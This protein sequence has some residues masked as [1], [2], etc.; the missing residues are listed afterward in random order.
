MQNLTHRSPGI[1]AIFNAVKGAKQNGILDLG[2]ATGTNL[3]FYSRLG[4]RF[5]FESF[6]QTVSGFLADELTETQILDSFLSSLTTDIKFDVV[7]FWDLLNYLPKPLIEPIVEKLQAV[8]KPNALVHMVNFVG[9]SIP[10]SPAVF[11]VADQYQLNVSVSSDR[12]KPANRVTTVALLKMFPRFL[13]VQSYLN[14]EGMASGFSEQILR[15]GAGSQEKGSV[16]SSSETSSSAAKIAYRINSPAVRRFIS[17]S[18]NVSS[19]L[20]L[21]TKRGFNH[22]FWKRDYQTVVASEL[23]PVI[24][25]YRQC[26]DDDKKDYLENGR[27][28]NIDVSR[29]FDVIIAWD[30]LNYC[31]DALLKAIGQRIAKHCNDGTILVLM[32]YSGSEIPASPQAF[33][34]DQKGV[35]L[36]KSP[37]NQKL[38]KK[39]PKV[40]VYAN[41]KIVAWLFCRS[42]ICVSSGDAKG[43]ERVFVCFQRRRDFG[44]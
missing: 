23:I 10:S 27:F 34:V 21:G 28:F 40:N 14:A 15:F 44:S 12:I 32:T 11:S 42:N 38:V 13:M 8:L 19:M 36:A 1:T 39:P 17:N 22:D 7:L 35:G 31:D 20:D 2:T 16:F 9:S 30:L 33:L 26:N 3:G 37:V 41:P 43:H 18:E 24:R 6:D 29:T 25:R 4:C 5:Q